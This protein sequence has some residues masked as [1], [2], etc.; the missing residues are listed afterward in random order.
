MAYSAAAHDERA[1]AQV[2]LFGEAT[3]ALP[4]PRLPQPE[5]WSPM[6][7]L[8]QEHAGDRLLP[9]RPPARRLRRRRCAAS[10]SLTHAELAAPGRRRAGDGRAARRHRRRGRPAQ[11]GARHPLRLRPAVRP[12][13][14]LRGADVLRRARRGA[15]P[16]RARPQR[17]ADRRGDARGRRAA[18][19]RQGT[20]SRSTSP[21]PAP[22]APACASTSTT[23]PPPRPRSPPASPQIAPR[24]RGSRKRGPI[25]LVRDAPRPARR[26][27]D[28]AA[29]HLPDRP[30]GRRRAEERCP[31]SFTSRSSDRAPACSRRRA[32]RGMIRVLPSAGAA[33]PISRRLP[34]PPAS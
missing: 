27:R 3:D 10:R 11:V 13:R 33:M 17:R 9:L 20:S 25:S 31:A 23:P 1:S 2:S 21:S 24:R 32:G 8:A 29:R 7:R 5:D 22:P 4:A 30:A 28:R 12:D 15:R 34:C 18:A 14:A 6:E 26:G 16:P 19:A